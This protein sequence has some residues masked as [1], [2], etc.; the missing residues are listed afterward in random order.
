MKIKQEVDLTNVLTM[1]CFIASLLVWGIRLE[2]R[3]MALNVRLEAFEKLS[4]TVSEARMDSID[5][6]LDDMRTDILFMKSGR[7]E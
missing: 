7:E 4:K 6:R 1:F 3:V 5:Q 2:D